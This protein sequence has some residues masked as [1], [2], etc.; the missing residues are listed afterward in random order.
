METAGN[1]TVLGVNGSRRSE[2]SS[3]RIRHLAAGAAVAVL[4]AGCSS[5]GTVGLPSTTTTTLY[6]HAQVLGWVTPTLGNGIS[7]V[8][9]APPEPTG[10]ELSASTRPLN[11]A[12]S[13]S[14]HELAEV[15]WGGALRSDEKAL[16][17]E[18]VHIE[19]ITASSP[20][21]GYLDQV[22]TDIAAARTDLQW[23][24]DAVRG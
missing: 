21:S 12:A 16:V 19:T 18:L 10:A 9:S 22:E 5:G 14:I 17:K 24:S 13:V 8:G 2:Q 20:G 15:P 4:L 1:A 6:T 3:H 11:T 7:F 23:L